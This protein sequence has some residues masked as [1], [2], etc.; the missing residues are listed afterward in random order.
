MNDTSGRP[1]RNAGRT[2]AAA[3][4]ATATAAGLAACSG[5][6]GGTEPRF[7]Y[8]LNTPLVTVNA[9]SARG[10]ATDAAKLS[11]RLY[12]GAFILGPDNRLL[13]N[14]DL[15]TATPVE[16]QPD[17]IDY[18]ISDQANYSDGSPVICDDFLLSWVAVST[19]AVFASSGGLAE[20]VDNVDCSPGQKNFRVSFAPGMGGRYR[21][22]FPA[23]EVLPAHAVAAKAKMSDR[24]L[25]D[26]LDGRDPDALA[27]VAQAWRD[28]FDLASGDVSEIPTSGPLTMASRGDSGE[29]TLVPNP[30][31]S[32]DRPGIDRIVVWPA[33][34][35]A[36]DGAVTDYQKLLDDQQLDVAD[37][38]P[39]AAAATLPETRATGHRVDTLSFAASGVFADPVARK[40]FASLVDRGA[41]AAAVKQDTGVDVEPAALRV[42][43][44]DSTLA[45]RLGDVV[46]RNSAVNPQAAGDALRGAT[47]RLG[48]LR[49]VPRYEAQVKALT[50]A[51]KAVG[52]TV[53]PVALDPEKYGTLGRD[54]DVLLDTRSSFGRN[55]SSAASATSTVPDVRK[56][57]NMLADEAMTVPLTAEPR[58]IAVADGVD[59]VTDNAGETGLSW[60]MDRWTSDRFLADTDDA[61]RTD[62][63]DNEEK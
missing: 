48:Y 21:E 57:E 23:G 22:L 26:T 14:H 52:I 62:D 28:E 47:V 59:N 11:A 25:V 31:W 12:P 38:A 50:A 53:E 35:G 3:V 44:P 13:P 63:P 55:P 58:I 46:E 17:Q 6:D 51:A 8:A 56:A 19:P 43:A 2:A 4:L 37:V 7:G 60:N 24:D 49:G 30:E 45:T 16:G 29:L 39:G 5:D 34:A 1:A 20:R 9:A 54:Y 15:V 36:T 40:G 27:P 42:A 33:G 10:V 41:V 18:A 32:G 61:A